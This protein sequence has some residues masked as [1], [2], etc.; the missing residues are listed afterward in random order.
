MVIHHDSIV[1]GWHDESIWI[2]YG[3]INDNLWD[4][5]LRYD[6][7]MVSLC[8]FRVTLWSFDSLLLKIALVR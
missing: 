1:M 2:S 8:L 6:D 3:F 4:D 7:S 5:P